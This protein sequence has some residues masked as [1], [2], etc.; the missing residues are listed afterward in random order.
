MQARGI[1]G[2]VEAVRWRIGV[3]AF[4]VRMVH[5][6]FACFCERILVQGWVTNLGGKTQ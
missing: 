3:T 6:R 4:P 1:D 5:G 2:Y